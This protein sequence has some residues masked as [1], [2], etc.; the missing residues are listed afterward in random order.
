MEKSKFV[1]K[2]SCDFNDEISNF[3]TEEDVAYVLS[4]DR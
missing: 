1:E 2:F 3:K 4:K